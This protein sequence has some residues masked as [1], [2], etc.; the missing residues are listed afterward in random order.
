MQDIYPVV[1]EIDYDQNGLTELQNIRDSHTRSLYLEYPTV[2]V[3]GSSK[4]KETRLIY[5]GETSDIQ[6]RTI[7]HLEDDAKKSATWQEIN[8]GKDKKLIVIGHEHFNKSMTLDIENQLILYLS[9]AESPHQ[10]K[11]ARLNPQGKYYPMAERKRIFSH[12]WAKLH[13][14]DPIVFPIEKAIRDSALFKASP[15]HTLTPSQQRA[16]S[17]IVERVVEALADKK[18]GQVIVVSGEA[19]SGKTVLLSSLFY[20]LMTTVDKNGLRH[21]DVDAGQRLKA[22]LM[23]NHEQQLTVYQQIMSKLGLFSKKG[24]EVGKPTHFISPFLDENHNLIIAEADKLD[25]ILVDEG[26]LLYSQGKQSYRGKNQ[27]DDLSKMAR[28]VIVVMDPHQVLATNE[29]RTQQ[30]FKRLEDKAKAQGNLVSLTDQ[31]RM[32]ADKRTLQWV[33][34]FVFQ[35]VIRE[36]PAYDAKGFELKI[37]SSPAAMEGQF[38]RRPRTINMACPACWRRSIGSTFRPSIQMMTRIKCGRLA[39]AIGQCL[40]T[41]SCPP[42]VISRLKSTSPWPG[43]SNPKPLAKSVQLSLF[44]DWTSIML[45]LFLARRLVLKMARWCHDLNTVQTTMP[46]KSAVSMGQRLMLRSSCSGMKSMCS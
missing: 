20:E 12:I 1:K 19:G 14:I 18:D 40:G 21:R 10:L 17:M 6:H 42:Q 11:N 13:T 2:Y 3:I 22:K 9:G 32:Q 29:Y 23:V 41:C 5:V 15:F 45:G 25:V 27:L 38:A 37:F 26:H 7:Q 44:R 34:D 24:D 35:Q 8:Q 31:M 4:K 33:S 46:P 28:V 43:R 39:L 36:I 30:E 16:K